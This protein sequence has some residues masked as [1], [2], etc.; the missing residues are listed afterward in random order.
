MTRDHQTRG[1]SARQL[2]GFT[3]SLCC[4]VSGS[5]VAQQ[6]I[7]EYHGSTGDRLGLAVAV[8]GDVDNDGHDDFAIGAPGVNVIAM[9]NVGRVYVRSG[10]TGNLLFQ[11][12][13]TAASQQIGSSLDGVGDVDLDGVPDIVVGMA[14]GLTNPGLVGHARVVSGANG[15]ILIDVSNAASPIVAFAYRVSGAGDVDNDGRPDFIATTY[16]TVSQVHSI[17]VYSGAVM[18][19]Q[20]RSFPI[21]DIA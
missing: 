14:G 19:G 3:L 17:A 6:L 16:G 15:S 2:Q 12:T 7:H 10:A 4:G 20:H 13:G 18:S 8:V 1:V 9:A 21:G 5:A 11:S